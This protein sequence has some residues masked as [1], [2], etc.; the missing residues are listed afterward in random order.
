M[1]EFRF[2]A[3]V[4]EPRHHADHDRRNHEEG[5]DPQQPEQGAGGNP[6][7]GR[8]EFPFPPFQEQQHARTDH[9]RGQRLIQGELAVGILVEQVDLL[10]EELVPFQLEVMGRIRL[11]ARGGSGPVPGSVS[12]LPRPTEEGPA[13]G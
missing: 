11:G 13:S 5:E 6:R 2:L 10:E 1:E 9:R 7:I 8:V 3:A 4:V 12:G